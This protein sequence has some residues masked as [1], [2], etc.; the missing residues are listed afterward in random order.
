LDGR[1]W[2]TSFVASTIAQ[3]NLWGH[4][5]GTDYQK[6][7]NTWEHHYITDFIEVAAT[8]PHKNA[9]FHKPGFL[10]TQGSVTHSK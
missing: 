5:K 7:A 6:R 4:L 10:A 1:T 3:S 2:K 9:I 8:I